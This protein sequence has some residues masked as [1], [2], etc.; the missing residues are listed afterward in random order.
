[1][2]TDENED[3]E[4]RLEREQLERSNRRMRRV[5][6]KSGKLS[7]LAFGP[8][9]ISF[10]VINSH[11]YSYYPAPLYYLVTVVFFVSAV[12]IAPLAAMVDLVLVI[13]LLLRGERGLMIP[14]LLALPG[15]LLSFLVGGFLLL[16]SL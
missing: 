7:I 5:A 13:R 14:L 12:G 2:G 8:A 11:A 10:A 9:L 1:M 4:D 15:V 6:L 3:P 16:I